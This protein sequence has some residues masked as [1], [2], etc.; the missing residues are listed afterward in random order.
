MLRH[1]INRIGEVDM[2]DRLLLAEASLGLLAARIELKTVPFSRIARRIGG[3]MAPRQARDL[4]A[5]RPLSAQDVALARKI[6]WAVTRAARHVPFDAVCLPQAMAA[7]GMLRKRHI[8]AV[9]HFGTMPGETRPLDAHAWVDAGD[10]EVTGYP[11]SRDF[12]E[13]ACIA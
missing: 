13:I 4:A 8:F 10:V 7:H 12:T 2:R 11:V 3:F 6:G 1:R 9:I 5:T